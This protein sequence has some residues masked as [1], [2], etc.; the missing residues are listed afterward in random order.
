MSIRQIYT[1]QNVQTWLVKSFMMRWHSPWTLD[2][3][4]RGSSLNHL[5][6]PFTGNSC[7][8]TTT[9]ATITSGDLCRS[10]LQ[11]MEP[12]PWRWGLTFRGML[13]HP[14][15]SSA[16]SS[17]PDDAD[18]LA[19]TDLAICLKYLITRRNKKIRAS[20]CVEG[21]MTSPYGQP[22]VW[23]YYS[24]FYVCYYILTDRKMGTYKEKCTLLIWRYFFFIKNILIV[25]GL[26]IHWIFHS[27]YRECGHILIT[28]VRKSG[29]EY[30]GCES[31]KET[32]E[33]IKCHVT[34]GTCSAWAGDLNCYFIS[35]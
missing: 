7:K 14:R 10:M 9:T 22:T 33:E 5:S 24:I 31:W 2:A 25:L 21:V 6:K 30:Q 11:F 16:F 4:D 19:R 13:I 18:P 34:M 27:I 28:N 12:L 32:K 1:R 29:L 26:F 35:G 3:L 17:E 8:G 23:L 20:G 15:K